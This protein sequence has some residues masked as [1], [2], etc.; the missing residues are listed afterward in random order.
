MCK[1][2]PVLFF[3]STLCCATLASACG[4]KVLVL[5]RGVK[6]GNIS[7][8]YNA[9]I[10]A[11]IPESLPKSAAVNDPQFQAALRKTGYRL[12]LVQQPDLLAEAVQSGKYDVILVDVEDAAIVDRQVTSA[13]VTTVVMP[14][15]YD[16]SELK[17]ATASTYH[18][19][20]ASGK[21][22]NCSS[23]IDRAIESKLKRDEQQ[24][25]ASKN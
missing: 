9:S 3:A 1:L 11:Y 12:R 16:E 8:S 15:V 25:R 14:V 21:K 6:F 5:G 10:I 22:G 23:T 13:R 24:R 20:R 4:D 17:T 7:S 19:V 18:C 2:L